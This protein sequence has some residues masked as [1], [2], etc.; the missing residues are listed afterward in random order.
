MAAPRDAEVERLHPVLQPGE[1]RVLGAHVLDEQQPAARAQDATE[2]AQGPGL[3]VDRAQHQRRDRDVEA[4]IF[5]RQVLGRRAEEL[6]LWPLTRQSAARAA[7][8][9][10]VDFPCCI[11]NRPARARVD[12]PILA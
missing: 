4:F 6:G 2:L 1:L 10:A 8:A 7:E 5:E 11:A 9:F 12:A 3:V